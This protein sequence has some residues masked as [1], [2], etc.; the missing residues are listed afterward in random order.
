MSNIESRSPSE[1]ISGNER[2]IRP[3]LSDAAFFFSNDKNTPGIT[4][5]KIGERRISAQAGDADQTHRI[6]KVA[7]WLAAQMD[8]DAELTQ[9]AVRAQC[10]LVAEMVLEFPELQGIAGSLY[11]AS[12]DPGSREAINPITCP[13]L[14][15]ISYPA[16]PKPLPL[17]SPTVS[18]PW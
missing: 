4:A 17:R 8:A 7:S 5:G 13:D 11:A 10:D 12:G 2:V 3:R 18:I 14:Q 6:A 9:R 16:L 1:V 15:V